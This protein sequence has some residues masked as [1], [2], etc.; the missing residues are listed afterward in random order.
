MVRQNC[1]Q[2]SGGAP[3]RAQG[4]F[5]GPDFLLRSPGLGSEACGILIESDEGAAQDQDCRIFG[6]RPCLEKLRI[7]VELETTRGGVAELLNNSV[8]VLVGPTCRRERHTIGLSAQLRRTC[9]LLL[10]LH[11][12]LPD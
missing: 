1:F 7:L 5:R 2:L 3:Q 8:V 4:C 10:A 9:G 6:F 12:N 11:W